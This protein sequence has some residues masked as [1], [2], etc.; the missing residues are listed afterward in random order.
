MLYRKPLSPSYHD[1]LI[2][3][4]FEEKSIPLF[5]SYYRRSLPR[6]IQIKWID[7]KSGEVRHKMALK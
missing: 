6:F 7:S 5:V 3:K 2:Y 4:S 1:S